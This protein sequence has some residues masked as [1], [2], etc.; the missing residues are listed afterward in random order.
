MHLKILPLIPAMAAVMLSACGTDNLTHKT[1]Q[2]AVAAVASLIATKS[3]HADS[4]A[5]FNFDTSQIPTADLS[6]YLVSVLSKV[7]IESHMDV[8]DPKNL[9]ANEV[10]TEGNIAI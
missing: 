9:K 2:Q 10:V 8:K 3:F 1:A 4:T 5:T 6:R 7:T